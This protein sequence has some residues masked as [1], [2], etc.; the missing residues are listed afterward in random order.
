MHSGAD[1]IAYTATA[2]W[3]GF[4]LRTDGN[5][6]TAGYTALQ[7]AVR[8][9]TD[10]ERFAIYLRDSNYTSLNS[11]LPLSSY[12]GYPTSTGW[13]VYTIPLA[14]LKATNVSLGSIVFHNWT[15][16]AQGAIYIDDIQ[17]ISTP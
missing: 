8:S 7:F 11:P 6:S 17:L 3:A 10:G 16:S 1:S 14:D 12:G 9:T 5:V 2:G 13:T 15:G 4:Q